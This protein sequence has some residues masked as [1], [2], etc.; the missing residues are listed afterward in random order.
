MEKHLKNKVLSLKELEASITLVPQ[1]VITE[2]LSSLII[3]QM[4]KAIAIAVITI[5]TFIK[6]FDGLGGLLSFCVG[7]C[8]LPQARIAHGR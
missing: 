3:I 8:K 5:F 1:K 7:L 2:S 4:V 6:Q